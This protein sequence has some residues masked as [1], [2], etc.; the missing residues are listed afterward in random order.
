MANEQGKLGTLECVMILV[1][2][3]V[4]SAVFSL[5]G[6]TYAMAG[7]GTIVSWIIG[8]LILLLYGLE[9]AE[10]CSIYPESGGIFVFPHEALGKT[11][12]GKEAWGWGAA[13]SLLNVNIF[14]AAFSAIYVATYLGQSFPALAEHQVLLAVIWCVVCGLLCL[15]NITVAG[16]VNLVMVLV[17]IAL[18]L[19]YFFLGVG[20]GG[21]T[22]ENFVPFFTRGS[23]GG[24]GF[25]SAIPVAM[26]AY[27]AI[28]SVAFMVGQ[29][30]NPKKTVPNSM[31]TAMIIAIV[32]YCLVIVA[33]IGLLAVEV[34]NA[35]DTAWIQYVP[36]YAVAWFA[37]SA[38]PWLHYVISIAA[39]LALTTTLL[40][41][42]M[43][44]GWT[45]QAAAAKGLLPKG[46]AKVSGKTGTPVAA[47]II[48]A[49]A[50][51]AVSCFPGF[52]EQITNCGAICNAICVIIISITLVAARKKAT[53][54]PGNFRLAG[55]AF[56]PILV[57]IL[58]VIFILPG[59]FQQWSY[60]GW[61]LGWYVLGAI[62]FALCQIGKGKGE[63]VQ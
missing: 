31:I 60:W 41:L 16:K 42:L 14:G 21:F 18:M 53:P 39:V 1:G 32:M 5:S 29:V 7:P 11:R 50:T 13:W 44:A 17:L 15:F 52:V 34:F 63:K 54:Q 36:L 3:M 45:V 62:I 59:I 9:T 40:V 23:L 37:L 25:I 26:L 49:V 2:G 58:V 4:G 47:M 51:L 6:L 22:G 48:C 61:A 24:T 30:K 33:T 56:F 20:S 57:S 46:L 43:T 10:L 35:P 19:L 27:G 28:V 12:L 8:G 55:G 38:I